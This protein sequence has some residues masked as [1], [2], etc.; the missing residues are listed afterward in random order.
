[1]KRLE[2]PAGGMPF[3]GD[4]LL[5]MDGGY[6]DAIK[7]VANMLLVSVQG[8]KDV[9]I[10]DGCD[11][12]VSGGVITVDPGWL[13]L[14]SKIL[15]FAGWSGSG[16]PYDYELYYN[17]IYD[18]AGS[19]VFADSITRDTYRLDRA[20]V[21]PSTVPSDVF[22]NILRLSNVNAYKVN[23]VKKSTRSFYNNN[24]DLLINGDSFI[25]YVS[26]GNTVVSGASL[27]TIDV[28]HRP[29][30]NASPKY[31]S[32]LKNDGTYMGYVLFTPS[33]GDVTYYGTIPGISDPKLTCEF[34]WF[35][36]S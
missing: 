22:G 20:S 7:A 36:W 6:V 9:G 23:I 19:D 14:D 31:F 29:N 30:I 17:P 32:L 28:N 11:V 33:S 8:Y 10:I 2:I 3:E 27:A 24:V 25:M 4:D 35:R 1:M 26:I 21:R 15:Y 12:S 16:D 5:W 18:P 13:V 34:T